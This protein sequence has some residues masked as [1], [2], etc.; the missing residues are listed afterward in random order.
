MLPFVPPPPMD[1]GAYDNDEDMTLNI[2]EPPTIYGDCDMDFIGSIDLPSMESNMEKHREI[3]EGKEE[4]M[5]EGDKEIK[6]DIENGF[7]ETDFLQSSKVFTT[8][9]KAMVLNND[10]KKAPDDVVL[11]QQDAN[12]ENLHTSLPA[13]DSKKIDEVPKS[14]V[15]SI[16]KKF[17]AFRDDKP[18]V[19]PAVPAKPT[20]LHKKFIKK[21]NKDG[22]NQTSK[23]E[24]LA[25]LNDKN[26]VVEKDTLNGYHSPGEISDIGKE[27]RRSFSDRSIPVDEASQVKE[28]SDDGKYKDYLEEAKSKENPILSS[29]D[30]SSLVVDSW[31]NQLGYET[32]MEKEDKMAHPPSS[33]TRFVDSSSAATTGHAE[34]DF[35]SNFVTQNSSFNTQDEILP[36]YGQTNS[37]KSSAGS[38]T[39]DNNKDDG[40]ELSGEL[41]RKRW[42][43]FSSTSSDEQVDEKKVNIVKLMRERTLPQ[44]DGNIGSDDDYIGKSITDVDDGLKFSHALDTKR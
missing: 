21:E 2:I 14:N 41:L 42:S 31:I 4:T 12:V 18:K 23:L 13:L 11:I 10:S 44:S 39:R 43:S 22:G 29:N 28:E 15:L 6:G 34:N 20:N 32:N 17:D 1:E 3:V 9:S 26:K 16:A 19:K 37:R 5:E 7:D 25:V 30:D 35:Y 40:M 27:R 33:I 24:N 8:Q 38:S 36:V